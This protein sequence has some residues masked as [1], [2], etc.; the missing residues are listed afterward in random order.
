MLC[1]SEDSKKANWINSDRVIIVTDR[2]KGINS[3]IEKE[4]NDVA[5][6]HCWNHLLSN[7]KQWLPKV[8]G[9]QSDRIALRAHVKDL[10][11]SDSQE[12]YDSQFL[13]YSAQNHL[14]S[15]TNKI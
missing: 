15:T 13:K 11:T 14:Y 3:A 8:C 9:T 12:H 5:Y 2:E 10:L 7:I 1:Y 4:L 6:V